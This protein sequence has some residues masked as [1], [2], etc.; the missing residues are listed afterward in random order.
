MPKPTDT[1]PPCWPLVRRL[2]DT[3]T[4]SGDHGEA[5]VGEPVRE[6]FRE[7]IVGIVAASAGAAEDAHRGAEFGE[8]AEALHELRLDAK[9]PPRI[10]V[11]PVRRAA[12]VEQALVGR[13]AEHLIAPQR[14]RSQV[15]LE[16]SVRIR[17]A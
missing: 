11:H 3:R 13:A 8:G 4:A 17:R 16:R 9:H 15:P 6:P 5:L 10:G 2:H 12:G 14:H 1:P 7:V